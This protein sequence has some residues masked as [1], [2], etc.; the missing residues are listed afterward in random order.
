MAGVIVL[1]GGGTGGHIFPAIAL[2][3]TIRRREPEQQV[4][5]I[6][7]ER[8]IG[9]KQ[10]RAAGYPFDPIPSAPVVGRGLL[11]QLRALLSIAGGVLRARRLLRG[12][13]ARLVIGVGGYASVPAVAAAITL[14]IPT[15]LLEADTAPGRANR[16]LGRFARMVFVQFDEARASFPAGRAALTGFPVRPIPARKV[17]MSGSP[18]RLLIIGGSQGAHSINRA[19]SENLAALGQLGMSITHQ[20]GEEDCE[21]VRAAYRGAGLDAEIS[22]F[23]DDV[24][25]RLSRADMVVARA[26]ASSVAEFCMAGLPQILVPYPY[27]AGGHQM[28]NA[29]E[30]ERAG[31][32]V[33]VPDAEA[34]DILAAEIAALCSDPERRSR[35]AEAA[36]GRAIP[37]AADQI[38]QKCRALLREEV[39]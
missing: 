27:A 17:R 13:D 20:T 14:R 4:C 9:T 35:L 30:L 18:L 38:W 15:V 8:G 24:P 19:I 10:I 5:F 2:A 23:F 28:S 3:D 36:R 33:V 32:C 11:D 1:S 31:A 16:L 7:T 12:V 29:R 39:S 26:G 37:G 22:P 25:E 34:G 6:G 21:W